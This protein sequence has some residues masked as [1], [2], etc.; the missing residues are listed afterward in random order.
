MKRLVVYF[1]LI[2]VH[3]LIFNT[4]AN[5]KVIYNTMLDVYLKNDAKNAKT[6]LMLYKEKYRTCNDLRNHP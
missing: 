6:F 3:S 1:V 2:I 4:N 5:A